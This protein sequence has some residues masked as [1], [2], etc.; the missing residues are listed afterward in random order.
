[1][2]L[3][4]FQLLSNLDT[5]TY[6]WKCRVR[7]QSIWKGIN[8]QTQQCWGTNVIFLDDSNNRIHAFISSKNV[9][10]LTEEIKEGV[11]YVLSNFKVKH[12]LGHETYRVVRADK[13]IY[14][15]EHTTCVKDIS[16]GLSIEPYT[17]D[18]FALEEIEK[19]ADD[20]RFLIDVVGIV[21]NVQGKVSTIKNDIETKRVVFQITD[22]RSK[23]NITLFNEF[24][25][26]YENALQRE[27]NEHVVIIMAAAKIHKYEGKVNLTNFPATRIYINPNHPSVEETKNKY[28]E[29]SMVDISSEDE[30]ETKEVI[31]I[32]DIKG[33]GTQFI[34]KNI[35]IEATIKR[36]DEKAAWYYARC[37]RCNIEV[38]Q[39]NGRYNCTNCKRIIPHPDKRFRVFSYCNDRTGSIGIILPDSGVRKLIKK[40]VFDI[41]AEYVQEPMI[42]PFPDELK[43]LQHKEYTITLK[44][45]EENINNGCTVYEAESEHDTHVTTTP[46][47]EMS[48]NIKIRARKAAGAVKFNVDD[49][50][51]TRMSKNIK[52]EKDF[53]ETKIHGFI[54]GKCVDQHELNLRVGNIC[55]IKDFIVQPYKQEDKFRPVQNDHQI[56]FSNETK[57]RDVEDKSMKFPDDAFDFSDH[58]ELHTLRK[59]P[60]YLVDIVGIIQNR[61]NIVLRNLVNKR[62]QNQS[63]VKFTITYGSSNINIT[64]WDTLAHNFSRYL[65][66][67]VED[68]V[69]IIITSCRAGTWNDELDVSNV[70]ATAFY[71][72]HNH[73]SVKQ[74]RK[75]LEMP[76]YT[77]E[78]LA[79]QRKKK[80][81]LLTIADMKKLGGEYI[82]AHVL[83]HVN[84]KNVEE[85]QNWFY[86]ICTE[87]KNAFQMEDKVFYSSNCNRRIPH[88]EKRFRIQIMATDHS[89][90]MDII[91]EDREVRTLIGKRAET[92]HKENQKEKGLPSELTKL[93]NKNVTIQILIKEVNV[94]NKETTYWPNNICEGYYFPEEET[95]QTTQTMQQSNAET[96][97]STYHLDGMS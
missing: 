9:E 18:L 62:D 1:M 43:Q 34:E 91:L 6:D 39:Q 95:N 59:N 61:E 90:K 79:T 70:G 73:H 11:I 29:M 21:M 31:L 84:I 49:G 42:E 80:T 33:L 77:K 17:F 28:K 51:Q 57:I 72:N 46:T 32:S 8:K 60:M 27:D 54:P 37:A 97:N 96:S 66:Q 71:L 87:C 23:T 20:N 40:T 64:F 24:A 58:T 81:E 82:E 52:K 78:I 74:I 38:L 16:P 92:L 89:D 44:L 55:L 14:F 63:Q 3:N 56:I 75:M 12:Y 7:T 94:L 19:N 41:Q 67:E 35:T 85:K 47:T 68:P 4:K 2:S 36:M 50:L 13:H 30:D 10:K 22:G 25:E 69:I 15:T 5:K 26:S 76:N 88:P 93:A 83:L 45:N 65:L 48:T 86:S 53:Q